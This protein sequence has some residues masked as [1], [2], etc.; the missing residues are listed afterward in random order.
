MQ[1]QK[2]LRKLPTRP[3]Q[4]R[5]KGKDIWEW[6]EAPYPEDTA[7][8]VQPGTPE[9]VE[10]MRRRALAGQPLHSKED[11]NCFPPIVIELETEVESNTVRGL[12][13]IE[14]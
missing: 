11:R 4:I 8:E 5:Y 13:T 7:T 6:W 9:K 3:V 14:P 1:L 2:E 12:A 10:L